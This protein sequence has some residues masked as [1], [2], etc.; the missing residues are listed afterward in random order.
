MHPRQRSLV[1]G[2]V[3]D[4]HQRGRLRNHGEKSANIDSLTSS[5]QC[6]SSIDIDDRISTGQRDRIQQR[7]QPPPPRI[8]INRG[9]RR[10]RVGDAQQIIEQQQILRVCIREPAPAP[11]RPA[12]RRRLRRQHLRSSRATAWNG[13]SAGM[14][15]AE[16]RKH[17]R[18]AA[19]AT[20]H[21]AHQTALADARRSH[22]IHDATVTADR[23]V[24]Q[25][26]RRPSP[27]P[28]PPS[29]RLGTPDRATRAP[30]PTSRRAGTGSSAPLMRTISGSPR[31]AVHQPV[32]RW[33]R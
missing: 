8:R 28:G 14:R 18:T 22:H 7:G 6:A 15:L 32:A 1:F 25:A 3:G 10:I 19:R 26:P 21:L 9:Q 31:A 23:P 5:I 33:T 12:H 24:Q 2:T 16:G 11:W 20:P 17:L 13:T 29:G 27:T 30:M 4:Q